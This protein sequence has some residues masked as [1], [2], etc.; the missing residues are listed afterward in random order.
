[1]DIR[2]LTPDYAVSPQI[3]PE[4]MA[5]LKGLGFTTVIDN[6]PDGEIPAEWSAEVMAEAA[7]A[8]GLAFVV[9][10]IRPGDFSDAVLAAQGAAIA[11]G[12]KVFAYCASGNRSSCAWAMSA[13]GPLST[14][15]RIA[16][17]AR[18]G[19]NLEGLRARIAALRG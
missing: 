13:P 15:E 17:P 11:G 14:E 6:R 2:H 10:P 4:D 18:F 8:Q 12:G 3:T 1:M 9:N 16:I 7:A 19:Y 5:T